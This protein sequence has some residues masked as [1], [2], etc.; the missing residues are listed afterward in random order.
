VTKGS[1]IFSI[2]P[3]SK[4]QMKNLLVILLTALSVSVFSQNGGDNT[5]EFLDVPVSARVGALGGTAI[6][7]KDGDANLGLN[8][9]SLLSP[10]MHSTVSLTYLNYF[11]DINYGFVSYTSDF[12]KLGTFS[13]GLK[14]ISYG[15]F[16]ETDEGGN[17]LGE[18]SAGEY[19][20]VLGWGKSIDTSFSV[21]AN[22]KPIYSNLYTYNSFG[23]AADV[24]ATYYFHK[25]EITTALVVKNMGS[26]ITTY[27]EDGEREPLPF[28][29]QFSIS[30]K[31]K[32]VPLRLSL[33]LTN[34]ENWN[35]AYNDSTYLTNSNKNLTD[36]EKDE[37]NKNSFFKEGLR[38][39]VLGAEI[40]PSQSFN[41]RFGFNFKRRSEL[42]IEE[43]P[44]LVGFSWGVGFRIK[45]FQISYGSA[46]Y[47]LAGSSNHI[48][49]STNIS[50][51]Y[52][53]DIKVYKEPKEKKQK[54]LKKSKEE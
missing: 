2:F 27:V 6:A 53:R 41:L 47:H 14:Y 32:Y 34:I 21:G 52:K 18:F 25:R 10:D 24:S 9:P 13:T 12:K 44:G 8:N 28:E 20:L 22:L 51:S 46:R 17:E 49:I 37:R 43:K 4:A 26:Q 7:I 5:Y 33:T 16:T 38:H 1:I 48:T 3:S 30:K 40:I 42:A 31:L 35:L 23:L 54:K 39:V 45:R 19:A 29:I 11:A 15:K 36:E 50:Q